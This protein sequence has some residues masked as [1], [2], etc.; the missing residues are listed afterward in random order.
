MAFSGQRCFR[1]GVTM[2]NEVLF[3]GTTTLFDCLR[4]GGYRTEYIGK[5]HLSTK[6]K[7]SAPRPHRFWRWHVDPETGVAHQRLQR[8]APEERPAFDFWLG[9]ECY[10]DLFCLCYYENDADEPIL[11]REWQPQYEVDRAVERL[12]QSANEQRPF[13]MFVSINPPHP[14]GPYTKAGLHPQ[15]HG[16]YAPDDHLGPYRGLTDSGRDNFRPFTHRH[17]ENA[18]SKLPGYYGSISSVDEQVGRL[19]DKLEQLGIAD[20]TIVVYTGDHGDMMGSHGALGKQL[21]FEESI[22]VPMLV[23]WPRQLKP[24][25]SYTVFGATS[26]MPTLLSLCGLPVSTEVQGKDWS[27]AMRRGRGDADHRELL[28]YTSSFVRESP[29]AAEF[30]KIQA[31][32]FPL[33][34][35]EWR[36]VRTPDL[37]YCIQLFRGKATRYLYRL[38]DDPYQLQPEVWID[39]RPSAADSEARDLEDWLRAAVAEEPTDPFANWLDERSA[40]PANIGEEGYWPVNPFLPRA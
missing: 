34:E 10:N 15:Y 21:W 20:D 16:Y 8:V 1:N 36:G 38:K 2:N 14:G 9:N 18:V 3:P 11:G 19:L 40:R 24:H 33:A 17:S 22:N 37:T 4:G 39:E 23:R 30:K 12:Q 29:T 25:Q 26:I 35:G 28:E 31:K 5:W 6:F 27:A 13:A 32:F 7:E